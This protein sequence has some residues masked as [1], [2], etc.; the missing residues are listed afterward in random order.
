MV[1]ALL[2]VTALLAVGSLPK[3]LL[4]ERSYFFEEVRVFER[5]ERLLMTVGRWA[6]KLEG[7]WWSAKVF[8]FKID[9]AGDW[10]DWIFCRD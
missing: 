1:K 7:E 3:P 5:A 9:L 6:W 10:P 4:R 8:K 2:L